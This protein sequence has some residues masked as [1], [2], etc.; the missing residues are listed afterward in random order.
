V[1][2]IE[3]RGAHRRVQGGFEIQC[4]SAVEPADA[5]AMVELPGAVPSEPRL[6]GFIERD[7]EQRSPT[8]ADIDPG[9][10]QQL[11]RQCTEETGTLSRQRSVCRR[12]AA[13]RVELDHSCRRPCGFPA[14]PA[15]LED[16]DLQPG[17]CELEGNRCS[18]GAG[19][20]HDDVRTHAV[21]IVSAAAAVA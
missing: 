10:F 14:N 6:F 17:L 16:H 12:R 9:A 1:V 7:V 13:V 15:A 19:A 2:L 4:G 3:Q 8:I 5:H 11:S 20:Y 18:D 21:S